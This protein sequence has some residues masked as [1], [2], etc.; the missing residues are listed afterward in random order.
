[1]KLFDLLERLPSDP[2][3]TVHPRTA[4]DLEA[5]GLEPCGLGAPFEVPS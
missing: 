4:L 5:T 3:E 2:V 1:V